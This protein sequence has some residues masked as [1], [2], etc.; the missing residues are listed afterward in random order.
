MSRDSD[1][2]SPEHTMVMRV[3]KNSAD[4]PKGACLVVVYGQQIGRRIELTGAPL[5]IGRS[6]RN[7]L[8]LDEESVSRQHVRIEPDPKSSD[9][10]TWQIVD[11]DST[12][13]TYVN[14]QPVRTATL[15]HGDQIQVGRSILRY[16]AGNSIERAYHEEIYKLMS[17]DGLT[18]LRNRRAFD[19][20]L[21]EEIARARRF[22]R[23]LAVCVLDA[24]KFKSINDQFGHLAG[25]AVLRQLGGIL[26][27][28]V[29][30]N[31][32]AGRLGGEEFGVLLPEVDRA[33]GLVVAEKLRRMVEA[34]RFE[35]D[36]TVI[37]VTLSIGVAELMPHE[38]E[39][40][41]LIKRA[42]ELL[43]RAKHGGRNRVVG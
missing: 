32:I 25:D 34:H 5:V 27:N 42:D 43:Y 38:R 8:Q 13:G 37:P 29:R 20:A 7:D 31:D 10:V 36:R 39:P 24:D 6:P 41:E 23:P 16:L 21:T 18:Q 9:G 19:E 35:F 12:N 1:T 15:R 26:R 33:G 14:D 22:E 3:E 30:K 4:G 2:T 28:N 40:S 11:L 17:M